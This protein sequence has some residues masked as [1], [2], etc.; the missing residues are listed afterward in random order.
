MSLGYKFD[1]SDI[2]PFA[3]CPA[4]FQLIKLE[5][6][7]DTVF[8]D[9]GNCPSCARFIEKKEIIAS[10]ELYL[11]TTKATQTAGHILSMYNA[12]YVIFGMTFISLAIIYFGEWENIKLLFYL[13]LFM[14]T[15]ML[16]GGFFNVKNWLFEYGKIQTADGDFVD[17]KKRM[18]R[19]QTVWVWANIVNLIWIVIFIK[20]L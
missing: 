18:R 8:T 16:I 10:Y 12:L 9:A 15:F 6:F 11:K 14:T 13:Y 4:C 7:G 1:D 3:N 17:A 2:I 5:S 20:F 19:A